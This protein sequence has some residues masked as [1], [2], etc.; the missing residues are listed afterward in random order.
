MFL[1]VFGV[2]F[3]EVLSLKR[4]FLVYTVISLCLASKLIELI[5][6]ASFWPVQAPEYQVLLR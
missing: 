4:I 6:N 3:L 2:L 5:K 1:E